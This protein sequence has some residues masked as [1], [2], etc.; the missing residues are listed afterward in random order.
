[1]RITEGEARLAG[2]VMGNLSWTNEE[3]TIVIKTTRLVIAYLEGK[4]L[5]WQRDVSFLRR[6][7]HDFEDFVAARKRG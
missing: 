1:M 7:L 2:E 3:L 5:A 4:G 6:E